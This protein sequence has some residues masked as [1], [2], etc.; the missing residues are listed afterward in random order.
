MKNLDEQLYLF[1]KRLV[2]DVGI[3]EQYLTSICTT[4]Y[5]ELTQLTN[6]QLNKIESASPVKL[7][8]R[9][10]E[11]RA[12]NMM[13]DRVNAQLKKFPEMVRACKFR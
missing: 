13:M 10:E 4:I 8:F 5:K 3:E 2:A 6:E 12:F 7:E 1:R 11:L 9:I